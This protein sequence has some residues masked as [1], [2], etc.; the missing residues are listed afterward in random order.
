M[1]NISKKLENIK[2]SSLDLIELPKEVNIQIVKLY[3]IKEKYGSISNEYSTQKNKVE[4]IIKNVEN[5]LKIYEE[6]IEDKKDAQ[7]YKGNKF[8][9]NLNF[10][11]IERTGEKL[12][13]LSNNFKASEE[14]KNDVIKGFENLQNLNPELAQDIIDYQLYRYGVNNKI[15]SFIDIL[16]SNINIQVS[17]DLTRYKKDDKFISNNMDNIV[18]NIAL[19]NKEML[20]DSGSLFS[21][22]KI[23]KEK[24]MFETQK[25]FTQFSTQE[26]NKISI[27]EKNNIKNN[28]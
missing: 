17:K 20:K 13:S 22:E 11:T 27:E 18:N 2:N 24:T 25:E 8:I 6:F 7:K 10:F 1:Y 19:K 23:M 5:K 14:I 4:K 28:C 12:V 9:E 21:V 15:G 3:E 16:P 26:I